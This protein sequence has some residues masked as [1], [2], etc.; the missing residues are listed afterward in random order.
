MLLLFVSTLNL[1]SQEKPPKYWWGLNASANYV[2]HNAE[3][4]QLRGLQTCCN[5]EDPLNG[6]TGLNYSLGFSVFAPIN[7]KLFFDARIMYHNLSG[8]FDKVPQLIG[9]NAVVLRDGL[10]SF[11]TIWTDHD[12]APSINMIGIEPGLKYYLFNNFSLMG[13]FR[14]GYIT[15]ANYNYDEKLSTPNDVVFQETG[16]LVRN[17]RINAEVLDLIS[18]QIATYIG[19]AYYFEIDYRTRIELD[20]RFYYAASDFTP[21]DWSANNLTFGI[22]YQR[23]IVPPK[24]KRIL[25]DTIYVRDTTVIAN[26]NIKEETV[27]LES[28]DVSSE[29]EVLPKTIEYHYTIRETYKKW[30]PKPVN[31]AATINTYGLTKEGERQKNP[32]IVIEEIESEEGFPLLPFIYFDGDNTYLA[33]KDYNVLKKNEFNNFDQ[34]KLNMDMKDVYS[35]ILNILGQRAKESNQNISLVGFRSRFKGDS[36]DIDIINARLDAVANYFID[37]CG[38]SEDRIKKRV[39]LKTVRDN[40]DTDDMIAEAQSVEIEINDPLSMEPVYIKDIVRN[41]TPPKVIIEGTL[42]S[43]SGIDYWDL[44]IVQND[45]TIREYTGSDSSFKKE[46]QI[47]KE[48][49]PRL[50]TPIRIGLELTDP[51]GN[52]I[53]QAKSLTIRQLTIK[54][55]REIYRNDKKIEKYSLIVFDYNKSNLKPEHMSVVNYIKGKI[56]EKSTVKISGYADRTGDSEY[57]YDLSKRRSE[58]VAKALNLPDQQIEL[59]PYGSSKQPYDNSTALGRALSRTV[60]IEIE[61]PIVKEG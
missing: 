45:K 56:S 48:P 16:T 41:A 17:S 9:N 25:K 52:S 38:I 39:Q 14:L 55:K 61:T 2:M 22:S 1:Y 59:V 28:S 37:V 33:K 6:G 27:E 36:Q 5:P 40:K 46:W 7:Q 44:Q 29:K 24:K 11:E 42:E 51:N 54:K 18:F 13:G 30:L 8:Q 53:N 57:N 20:T 47:D 43:E 50:E 15:T 60:Q 34:N 3:F 12:F 4:T 21:V 10:P 58:Q 49:I 26:Y 35:N 31:M 23:G 32:K 19:A